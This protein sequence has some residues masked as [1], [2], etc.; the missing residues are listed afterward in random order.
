MRPQSSVG[1]GDKHSQAQEFGQNTLCTLIEA[2]VMPT[3]TS[4]RPEEREFAVDSG[5][6]VHMMR[7]K[8]SELRRDGH[9]GKGPEPLQW[10]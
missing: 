10:C 9:S 4:T 5:A 6:S 2:K 3:P 1:C 8:K 7:K